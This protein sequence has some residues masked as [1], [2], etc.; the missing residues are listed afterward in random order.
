MADSQ[1][2]LLALARDTG[3]LFVRE[4]NLIDQALTEVVA[5][6]E[7]YYL[8]GYRPEAS[9]FDAKTG[10]TLYHKVQVRLRVA[11]L[12]V[13]SRSGFFGESDSVRDKPLSGPAA[14]Q[15]A[16]NSPFASADVHVQLTTLFNQTTDKRSNLSALLH[17]DAHELSFTEQ[18][19][20]TRHANFEVAAE[21]FGVNGEHVDRS[22][23]VFDVDLK[24]DQYAAALE[25]GVVYVVNQPVRV[26]GTYQMRV[27]LRDRGSERVGAANQFIDVPDLS[28]GRLALSSILLRPDKHGA[29]GPATGN[30][31]ATAAALRAFKPG[32]ALA[33]DYL[34]FNTKSGDARKADLEV[35]TRLFR[36]GRLVYTG[37]PMVPDVAGDPASGRL[38]AG[39]HMTLA[40]GIAPGDYVF[41]LLVTDKLAKEQ[42]RS[43]S[44]AIDFEVVP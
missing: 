35:Q 9:T 37:R 3:G 20:G 14:L 26:P 8:I 11:G 24:P 27:A 40:T 41:Q 5:D 18:P 43:A 39:G 31:P 21:I 13:R 7:G 4:N 34:V 44:Q 16:L 19:D 42:Y 1:L 33:Y 38:E 10:A 25:R 30:D 17:I 28:K 29:E 6:S 23:R 32:D 2:G 12:R 22:D 36:G 15:H